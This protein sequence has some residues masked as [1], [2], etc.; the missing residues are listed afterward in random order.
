M[1][2]GIN[3]YLS[4]DKE[5]VFFNSNHYGIGNRFIGIENGF[6]VYL[7]GQYVFN[8]PVAFGVAALN[9]QF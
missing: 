9:M 1:R 5:S 8:C 6:G 2:R 3:L 4:F 7:L